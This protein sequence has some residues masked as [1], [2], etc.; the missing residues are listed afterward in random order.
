MVYKKLYVINC[1]SY[2][3]ENVIIAHDVEK[4]IFLNIQKNDWL[5]NICCVKKE[6]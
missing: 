1:I 6:K 5:N 3:F 4:N 2:G